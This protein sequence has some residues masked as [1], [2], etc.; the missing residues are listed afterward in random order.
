MYVD[1][2]SHLF[3]DEFDGDRPETVRRAMQAGVDRIVLP[4]IDAGTVG[5]MLELSDEFTGHCL[6]AIG[7]HPLS[8]NEDYATELEKIDGWLEK[9]RFVAIG[10]TGIDL[11]H[12]KD[13]YPLQREAFRRQ[14]ALA[15]RHD[16]PLIIHCRNS[17]EEVLEVLG[18]SDASGQL[19]GI[20]H[21]FTGSLQQA[22]KIM[23]AGFLMGI[24][25]VLTFKNS[26]LDK[27]VAEIPLENFVLET[28]APYLA[29]VPFRGKRNESAYL[30]FTAEK[31]ARIHGKP[32]G[33]VA[34]ITT[35]NAVRLFNIG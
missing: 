15:L 20:F 29:P 32:V 13:S 24:G 25:G 6:P 2:H 30:P 5:A 3:L 21:C 17:V 28:D 12:A 27:V 7:L 1:T 16:L 26:G 35:A 9:R 23:D 4:N 33:E 31:L 19:R 14:A 10:E 34:A 11:Y 8:V 18:E 22:R